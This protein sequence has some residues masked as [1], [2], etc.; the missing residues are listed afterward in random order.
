MTVRTCDM[1]H[2]GHTQVTAA[3]ANMTGGMLQYAPPGQALDGGN[4]SAFIMAAML[5]PQVTCCAATYQPALLL[6]STVVF[7]PARATHEFG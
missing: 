6:S 4:F 5:D 3:K 1:Q 7:A 2:H